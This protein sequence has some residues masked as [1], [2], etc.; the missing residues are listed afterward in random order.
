MA[1][2]TVESPRAGGTQRAQGTACL[3]DARTACSLT[4]FRSPLIQNSLRLHLPGLATPSPCCTALVTTRSPPETSPDIIRRR[5]FRSGGRCHC[6][7]LG[8]ERAAGMLRTRARVQ[9]RIREDAEDREAGPAG[10]LA[11]ASTSSPGLTATE[12]EWRTAARV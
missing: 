4:S 5:Y 11:S 3:T 2:R 7:A 10:A 9:K 8:Q 6:K 1:R 12:T